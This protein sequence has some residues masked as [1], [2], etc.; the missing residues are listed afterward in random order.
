M[1][2]K[3]NGLLLLF[4]LL[5]AVIGFAAGELMLERLGAAMPRAV[6]A[7]LYFG[8]LAFFIGLFSLIAELISPRLNGSS[9]R[10]RYTGLS[11]KL[12]LPSTLVLLFVAGALLQLGYQLNLGGIKPAQDIVFALDNSGSMNETDPDSE[13]FAAVER[14]T[15]TMEED[16]RV[17]LLLFAD[18]SEE[19]LAFTAAQSAASQG[20]IATALAQIGK[21]DGGTNFQSVLAD[22]LG[23][24]DV[25]D[26]PGRG[27][28]VILLSDGYSDSPIERELEEYRNRQIAIH[29][30]GL[31][32]D[33]EQGGALLQHIAAQTGGSYSNVTDAVNLT[34]VFQSIYKMLDDR[35]L[36]T[37]RQGITADSLL[38]ALLRVTALALLG[39]AIG[40][41]L[42][43]IFDNR[44]LARSFAIGG[45]VGGLAAGLILEQGLSGSS[46]SDLMVRLAAMLVL[47]AIMSLFTL[48]V[49]IREN[50][51]IYRSGG[52]DAKLST[53]PGRSRGGNSG[54]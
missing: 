4:S 12:L 29:T 54:F 18:Q 31:N 2:R 9:W 16:K 51:R 13:R 43:L 44:F 37:Q 49:P 32:V 28:A 19:L 30:I 22:A 34:A 24:I 47:T 40:L 14:L 21:A 38:Y 36:V 52:R 8:V 41:G 25:K 5:G 11:W 3:L 7:G 39:A 10:Q 17:A 20:T 15:A 50:G 35:M 53:A 45:A 42:G 1:Q 6:A 23:V 26:Q 46:M 48:I 27:T 33:N